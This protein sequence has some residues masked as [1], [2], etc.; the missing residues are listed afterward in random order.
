VRFLAVIGS[1]INRHFSNEEAI[2]LVALLV[3]AFFVLFTLGWF[4][5]PILTAI[6]LAYLLQGL[7]ERLMR[8]RVPEL[9]AVYGT[10]VLFLG[11]LL[12]LV[13]VIFPLAWRQLST[14]VNAL[15]NLIVS[16][17]E[18]ARGLPERLPN[19]VS[20]TQVETWLG[21][22]GD[23]VSSMGRAIVQAIVGQVPSVLAL[24]I[25]L[26][27]VPISVFF[28]LKDR[29][30][31]LDWVRSLLPAERPLLDRVG[32][33]MNRQIANYTRGKFVEILIVGAATY[34]TFAILGMD[35][36]A[37]LGLIVGLSVLVP[38]IGAALV[39]VP[40]ALVGFLQWG[41]SWEFA[42]AMGAYAIIHALDANVLVPLLFSEAVNLHPLSIIVAVLVF[43]G[44]WGF[45]GVFFA[46]PL[47]T[48]VKAVFDAWPRAVS[49]PT[50]VA[51]S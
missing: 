37:L 46:I 42:Y 41:W 10:F 47:A 50:S 7:V 24:T 25:Y 21:M 17:Q 28:L 34:V 6:V 8:A 49:V 30:L 35:Y 27:L 38:F 2:Y 22:L 3:G 40:V 19:L 44:M 43:G 48:L 45:W 15:P 51:E 20:K 18:A 23:E 9:L 32:A 29:K 1:W 11:G 5:A 39:T 14:F 16:L 31:L 4:L 26:V 36:A 33:E 13:A 12:A